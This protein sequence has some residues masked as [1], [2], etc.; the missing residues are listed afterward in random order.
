MR[1]FGKY[2]II[3]I[4]SLV[5]S[6][7][8][9]SQV[10]EINVGV[11]KDTLMIGEQTKLT[12]QVIKDK[13]TKIVFPAFPD[14]LI[15]NIEIL[16]RTEIDT[17]RKG[18]EEILS[19]HF[20][21]TS[22][23]SATYHIPSFSFP[24][25]F[26]DI[27]D[28]VFSSPFIIKVLIPDVVTEEDF[29]DIKPPVNTPLNF[30]ELLPYIVAGLIF[31]MLIAFSI[32]LIKKFSPEKKTA[33]LNVE[34]EPPHI[35]AFRKLKKM[36]EEKAWEK[37][38][39]K[40]YYTRL[41]EII[42]I[43]LEDQFNVNAPELTTRE[44]LISFEKIFGKDEKIKNKLLELLQLSDLVKFAKKAP[45]PDENKIN[46]DKAIAFVELT[47]P[48]IPSEDTTTDNHNNNELKQETAN[49]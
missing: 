10:L 27:R 20:I 35:V 45:L 12:V 26:G 33:I 19:Q 43:Y 38:E 6:L 8:A 34:I 41:S 46:L 1:R 11:E 37:E 23:D 48:D 22:F 25:A 40:D 14:S 18:K 3:F 7:S 16:Y 15:K 2:S 9:H 42:R 31:L 39:I 49:E 30:K 47:K 17:I 4:Y 32:Y 24:I 28:T 36:E 21:I 44:T 29:K 13:Q 5:I